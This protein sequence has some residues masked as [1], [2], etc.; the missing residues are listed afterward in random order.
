MIKLNIIILSALLFSDAAHAGA[1]LQKKG[2]SEII[3]QYEHETFSNFYHI[4]QDKD[5]YLSKEFVSQ[6]YSV[7]YQYGLKDDITI[8]FDMKWFNYQSYQQYYSEN[9][10]SY[11]FFHE[12]EL[13]MDN[14]YKKFENNPYETKVFLQKEL[15]SNEDAV[16]SIQPS[17]ELYNNVYDKAVGIAGLYG[18]GFDWGKRHNYLNLEAGIVQYDE[19]LAEKIE[20]TLGFEV[21]PENTLMLKFLLRNNVGKDFDQYTETGQFSWL[22]KYN[23]HISWQTGYSTNIAHRHKYIVN[24]VITAIW[25]KL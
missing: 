15:W 20:V 10:E 11:N 7:F 22:Y 1:W 13:T 5:D 6:K 24:S 17:F 18:Y 14:H 16:F 9:N 19:G 21:I 3:A 4:P 8:G 23:D 25:I 12:S 2:R